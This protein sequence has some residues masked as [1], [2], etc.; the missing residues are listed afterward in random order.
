MVTRSAGPH[1]RTNDRPRL[2]HDSGV[3]ILKEIA[4]YYANKAT[5]AYLICEFTVKPSPES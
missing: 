4:N 2:A 5:E 3:K 1:H